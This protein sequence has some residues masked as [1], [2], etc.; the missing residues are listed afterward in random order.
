M[1]AEQD[2][3]LLY[4]YVDF[5]NPPSLTFRSLLNSI[6]YQLLLTDYD[7]AQEF[8]SSHRH[9]SQNPSI[10]A[11]LA[12]F[13]ST[14]RH[15]TSSVSVLVD[16]LDELPQE[17]RNRFFTMLS[18]LFG[19]REDRLTHLSFLVTSR[20]DIDIERGFDAIPRYLMPMSEGP[21]AQDIEAYIDEHFRNK[22][23]QKWSSEELAKAKA[24][25]LDIADDM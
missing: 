12:A 11:L 15:A 1:L 19:R 20:E 5:T 13:E 8:Y 17:Q 18:G 21:V 23:W 14:V 9:G 10:A 7:R 25:L 24:K 22:K 3:R 2:T 6:T 4:Y 16:G